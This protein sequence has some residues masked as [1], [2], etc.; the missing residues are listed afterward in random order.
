MYMRVNM[1]HRFHKMVFKMERGLPPNKIVPKFRNVVDE[2]R[3]LLPVVQALRNRALKERHWGKIFDIIGQQIPRDSSFTLQVLL[4]AKVQEWK[5]EIAQVSTEATQELALEELLAKVH[6]KWGD[7]EFVVMPYKEVK[8]TFILGGIE[9]VQVRTNRSVE[10]QVR[11][12][13]S[14]CVEGDV[15]LSKI[16]IIGR[17]I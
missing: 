8:D 17:I 11:T 14:V 16:L 2:Y 13:I 5:D 12:N 3:N 9:E 6:S 15:P 10:V 1:P 4:D 7:V